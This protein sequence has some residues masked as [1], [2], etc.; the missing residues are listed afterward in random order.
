MSMSFELSYLNADVGIKLQ[1]I[2]DYDK[3]LHFLAV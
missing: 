2:T 3:Q 1:N